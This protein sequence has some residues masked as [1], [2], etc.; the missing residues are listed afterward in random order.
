MKILV[1]EPKKFELEAI[2]RKRFAS[3]ENRFEL[4]TLVFLSMNGLLR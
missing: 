4:I 3:V 1:N 2:N